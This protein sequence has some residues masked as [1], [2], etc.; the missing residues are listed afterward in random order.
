MKSFVVIYLFF[1]PSKYFNDVKKA[2][3]VTLYLNSALLVC[4]FASYNFYILHRIV[5]LFELSIL[6]SVY[7]LLKSSYN[8]KY[9]VIS[10]GAILNFI[11]YE[12][13]VFIETYYDTAPYQSILDR[14]Y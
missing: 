11:L 1:I 12:Y 2:Y 13:F 9:L 10:L 5:L 14:N 6:C 3:N 4:I 7:V 8:R